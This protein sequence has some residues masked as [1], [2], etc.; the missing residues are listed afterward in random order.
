MTTQRRELVAF[1]VVMAEEFPR[2]AGLPAVLLGLVRLARRHHRF[3]EAHCNYGLSAAEEAAEQRCED[4]IQRLCRGLGC[5]PVFSGDPR[6]ATV[7]LKVPSGRTDDWGG[8][9]I[10]VP[11]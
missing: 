5:E 9:G 11:Q 7:K 4:A 3:Q 8:V 10:C 2:V 1:A 6:G